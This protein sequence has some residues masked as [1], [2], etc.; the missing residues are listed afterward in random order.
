MDFLDAAKQAKLAEIID[1]CSCFCPIF[2]SR[3]KS[4]LREYVGSTTINDKQVATERKA[5]CSER[6]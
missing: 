3:G 5:H 4:R 6:K 1:R 2:S